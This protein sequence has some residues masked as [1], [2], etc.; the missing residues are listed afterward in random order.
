MKRKFLASFLSICLLIGLLPTAAPLIGMLMLGNL[1]KESG[2]VPKL[3]ETAQNSFA[4]I[5]TILLG[6]TVA[7]Q[8]VKMRKT[9]I[10]N[11]IKNIKR[12]YWEEKI[13]LLQLSSVPLIKKVSNLIYHKCLKF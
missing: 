7:G 1:L 10:K 2:V 12:A 9:A 13:A 6:I 4:N 11:N 3:V 8:S 5:L